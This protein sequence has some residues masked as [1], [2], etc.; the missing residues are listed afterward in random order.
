MRLED[1]LKSHCD[2]HFDA[3]PYVTRTAPNTV[4]STEIL[5]EKKKKKTGLQ[6]YGI[7]FWFSLRPWF[8]V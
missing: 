7:F 4:S 2:P 6:I 8:P 5:Q 3:F 1:S